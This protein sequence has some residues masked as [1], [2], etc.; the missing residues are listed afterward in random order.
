MEINSECGNQLMTEADGKKGEVVIGLDLGGT[1]LAAAVFAVREEGL[2]FISALKN[3]KYQAMLSEQA[4]TGL[5]VEGRAKLIE[6]A[7]AGAV[8]EL[9]QAA[10]VK[11]ADAVGVASA[12][13]VEND[14]VVEATNIGMKNYPLKSRL[15]KATGVKTYLYKDSWAPIYAVGGAEPGI[16]F[17]IGTGFGGVSYETDMSVSVRSYSARRRLIWIPY[18]CFN[19]D[20]AYAAAYNKKEIREIVEMGV[21]RF[22]AAGGKVQPPEAA[23]RLAELASQIKHLAK[24]QKKM[25]PSWVEMLMARALAPRAAERVPADAIFA[26]LVCA[27]D[28]PSTLFGWL[29]DKQIAPPELDALLTADDPDA[30]L[31]FHIHAEFIGNVLA[32][33]QDERRENGLPTVRPI[34][35]T[36]SGFNSAN[37]AFLGPI[38][39][40]AM[41]DHAAQLDLKLDPPDD[42]ELLTFWNSETTLACYGAAV[43]AAKGIVQP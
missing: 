16:I 17:S 35:G 41:K 36:G 31:C 10:G 29:F 5:T 22:E 21:A 40:A 27:A 14:E 34:F 28:F 19:D 13:F 33:M 20:P 7:M 43:G 1:K 32:H 11:S 4:K 18:L 24:E 26:D 6:E 3:I 25:S 38:I 12:G 9:E 2:C 42:V 37:H 30:K 8:D 23:E 39:I 15:E